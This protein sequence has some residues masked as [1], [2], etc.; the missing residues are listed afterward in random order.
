M[1]EAGLFASALTSVIDRRQ[2]QSCT[3]ESRA[4]PGIE[5]PSVSYSVG[6]RSSVSTSGFGSGGASS[7]PL[8]LSCSHYSSGRSSDSFRSPRRNI[9]IHNAARKAAEMTEKPKTKQA[10]PVLKKEEWQWDYASQKWCIREDSADELDRC[11]ALLLALSN[12]NVVNEVAAF[13]TVD[14]NV[15]MALEAKGMKLS[16]D[17]SWVRSD[18]SKVKSELDDVEDIQ[19]DAC[20]SPWSRVKAF[21]LGRELTEKFRRAQE[22]HQHDMHEWFLRPDGTN[23]LPDDESDVLCQLLRFADEQIDQLVSQE[24]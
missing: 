24:D 20:S 16:A 9:R 2:A 4:E 14:P 1:T 22:N 5:V 17:G 11:R 23:A 6:S 13:T 8:S 18:N 10:K 7:S 12:V 3:H 19:V 15:N 21:A